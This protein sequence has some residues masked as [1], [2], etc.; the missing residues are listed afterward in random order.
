MAPIN[1]QHFQPSLKIVANSLSGLELFARSEPHF[2]FPRAFSSFCHFHPVAFL[3]KQARFATKTNLLKGE[4]CPNFASS[5]G[6]HSS[7]PQFQE[8]YY[9]I[10]GVPKTATKDEIKKAYKKLAMKYHPD[11]NKGDK[12][13]EKKFAQINNAYQVL[14]DE[15]KRQAYD[16]FGPDAEQMEGAE[17]VDFEELLRN[18]GFG[19]GGFGGQGRGG[20]GGARGEHGGF[21]F[22]EDMGG[23]GS[24]FGDQQQQ[25]GGSDR[26]IPLTISFMDAALGCEKDVT[27]RVFDNCKSCSGSGVS[28][29]S[30][31]T[32]CKTCGGSGMQTMVKGFTQI[33]TTCRTCQGRGQI[34]T[35][36]C[37]PCKGS[38]RVEDSRTITAHIPAGIDDGSRVRLANQ[39]DVGQN[40]GPRGHL[41]IHIKVSEHPF[42]HRE[43]PD[44]HCEVPITLSQALL[45]AV[46]NVPTLTGDMKLEVPP[47]TQPGDTRVLKDK[48]FPSPQGKRTG[49]Q[50]VH[51]KVVLPR[52]LSKKQTEAIQK[53]SEDEKD[54]SGQSSQSQASVKSLFAKFRSFMSTK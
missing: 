20:G 16:N 47:G 4:G 27:Y 21:S 14:S 2:F 54:T 37:K 30:K 34:N 1:Y 28:S 12:T 42:F 10:R 39:G 18:F 36:P 50:Y 7:R 31:L 49:S 8:D 43:G 3:A 13:M 33:A 53:F 51:F 35:N 48:G 52:N 32:T 38:G 45:G 24:I 22:F 17:N 41:F 29:G 9:S 23:F 11:A 6:F 46:V 25:R 44:L 15:S 5:R 26:Q 40:G 19:F